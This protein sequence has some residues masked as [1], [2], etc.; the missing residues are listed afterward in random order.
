MPN[1]GHSAGSGAVAPTSGGT[2]STSGGTTPSGGG[3]ETPI[4]R[5]PS[6]PAG[7]IGVSGVPTCGC[8][9]NVGPI[10]DVGPQGPNG[11]PSKRK[12]SY[13]VIYARSSFDGSVL[14]SGSWNTNIVRN[15]STNAI[16]SATGSMQLSFTGYFPHYTGQNVPILN[17]FQNTL[18][19]TGWNGFCKTTGVWPTPWQNGPWFCEGSFFR[20]SRYNCPIVGCGIDQYGLPFSAEWYPWSNSG[21]YDRQSGNA[22]CF[23]AFTFFGTFSVTSSYNY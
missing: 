11:V 8:I 23:V 3:G 22:N 17:E 19:N 18:S 4:S 1:K 7:N 12:R 21:D 2:P 15:A 5:T 13:G 10:G 16:I 6:G 20:S 9:G 14:A